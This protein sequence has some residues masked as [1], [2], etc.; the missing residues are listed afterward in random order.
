MNP[1]TQSIN[2]MRLLRKKSKKIQLEILEDILEK[3]TVIVAE[4]RKEM[5]SE[6]E[7]VRIRQ[8]KIAA[9]RALLL[10]HGIKPE[11]LALLR[12][13]PDKIHEPN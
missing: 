12:P 11:E 9:Y 1:F 3:F 8:Q 2:N 13:S 4:K 6:L 7:K 5:E 10:E